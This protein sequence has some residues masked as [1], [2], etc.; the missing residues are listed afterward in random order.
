MTQITITE[1]TYIF[2][3]DGRF[4]GQATFESDE[5]ALEHAKDESVW[6]DK[7]VKVAK[8]IGDTEDMWG[9]CEHCKDIEQLKHIAYNRY[10]CTVCG[11]T[12]II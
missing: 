8:W 10:L 12:N 6:R 4:F 7:P 5:A 9:R 2:Y 1:Y 11:N 3:C